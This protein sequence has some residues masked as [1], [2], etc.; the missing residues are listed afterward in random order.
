VQ[1]KITPEQAVE[2]YEPVQV[3]LTKHIGKKWCS[4]FA[5]E[6]GWKPRKAGMCGSFLDYDHPEMERVRQHIDYLLTGGGVHPQLL[7][8]Y[9]QLWKIVHR[10]QAESYAKMAALEPGKKKLTKAGGSHYLCRSSKSTC[11]ELGR[12]GCVLHD[13]GGAVC[14]VAVA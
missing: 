10:G 12:I 4:R 2:S 8:N 1:G 13:G 5:K 11:Q 14:W 3:K 9:D 7:L 6:F